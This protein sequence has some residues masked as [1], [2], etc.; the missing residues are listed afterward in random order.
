MINIDEFRKIEL[1]VAKIVEVETIPNRD[2]LYRL[3]LSLGNEERYIVSGIRQYYR[4]EELIG[5]KIVIIKN[6]EP[7]DIAGYT[8]NGMLLAA[9]NGN[10]LSL[11]TV[12]RDIPEGTPVS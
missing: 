8:S 7:R 11:L 5:K 3:K 4:P 6:L 1:V 2:K 10:S 9:Y 12:D